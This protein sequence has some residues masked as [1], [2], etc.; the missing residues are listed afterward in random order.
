MRT[1]NKLADGTKRRIAYYTCG[2]WKNKGTAVCN[3]NS[4]REIKLMNM[5]LVS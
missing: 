3:S 4:I 1:T 5:Y 2:N